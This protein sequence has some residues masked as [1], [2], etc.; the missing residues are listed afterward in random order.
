MVAQGDA[1]R[2]VKLHQA[3]ITQADRDAILAAL[4]SGWLTRGPLTAQFEREFAARVQAPHAL[5][6][7]SG[8]SA[9][10]LALLTAGIGLGDEVIVPALTFAATANV[11]V[12]C[13][14]IP[15]FADVEP[16]T[17]CIDPNHVAALI[18]P[19][20]RAIMPVHF[21][22]IPCEMTALRELAE[23]HGLFIVEDCAHAIEAEYDGTPMG[24]A[25]GS[26]FAAYSFYATKN[27]TTGEGG[28][29]CCRD[30]ADLRRAQ[31]LSQHG[32]S[33]NA[34][35]RDAGIHEYDL[36]AAGHKYNMNDLQAALGLSQ[37]ERLETNWKHRWAICDLYDRLIDD[38]DL[39][40]WPLVPPRHHKSAHHLYV[41]KMFEPSLRDPLRAALLSR[42][43]Q[44]SVHYP[45]LTATTFYREH[46][47]TDPT[48]TP[49]AANAA[50]SS[51]T[52]PLYPTMKD[53]DVERVVAAL[54]E[55]V[56]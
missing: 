32:L 8:T 30:A 51:I 38:A 26:R 27:I 17:H 54:A 36:L 50:Q 24:V 34:W 56:E 13:G 48:E 45:C 5:A 10:H 14:A 44:T 55:G 2:M 9:L 15:V 21:A 42:G 52:L 43:I 4:D 25:T 12:H 47:M 29:L 20:T 39:T 19:R 11:V 1:I 33:L 53:S 23:Q 35:Q 22:G 49:V 31:L 37:M 41:V 3:D 16:D 46:Y 28:M 6:V 7:N 18:T 40:M